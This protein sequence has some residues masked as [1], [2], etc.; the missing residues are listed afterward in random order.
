MEYQ[1]PEEELANVQDVS[2]S[3]WLKWS[4]QYPDYADISEL[5]TNFIS[6]AHVSETGRTGTN[7]GDRVLSLWLKPL[8]FGQKKYHFSTYA[9]NQGRPNWAQDVR[10]RKDED[11]DS[12]WTWVYFAHNGITNDAFAY[13]RF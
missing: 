2:F 6:I 10:V 8:S 7:F 1:L 5:K 9:D 4:F 12:V 13:M 3:F 11:F